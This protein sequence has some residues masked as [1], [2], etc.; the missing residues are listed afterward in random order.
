MAKKQPRGPFLD[1]RPKKSGGLVA[2]KFST[3]DRGPEVFIP[4]KAEAKIVGDTLH[5]NLENPPLSEKLDGRYVAAALAWLDK[6]W[7]HGITREKLVRGVVA[8]YLVASDNDHAK[9]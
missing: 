4:L 2:S 7:K 3:G 6:N 8:E 1:G 9:R 5:A